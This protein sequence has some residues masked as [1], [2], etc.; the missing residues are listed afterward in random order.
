MKKYLSLLKYEF[1]TIVKDSTNLFMLFYPFVL[2]LLLGVV[3]PLAMDKIEDQNS[4][5]IT[6]LIV[7][8][9]ALSVGAFMIGA[10]LGFSLIENK[11]EKT[12]LNISVTPI[13][14]SGYALFKIIYTY[15]FAIIGNIV[16]IGGLKLIASNDYV[17][18]INNTEIFLLD[19]L[20]WI[21]VVI[22]SFVGSLLVPMVALV[23]ASFAK[24]K[25][26]G[27]VFV[28]SGV[29]LML[30]PTLSLLGLF[31]GAKQ[32]ILGIAPNFWTVKAMLNVATM[33]V[34]KSDLNF[35]LYMLIGAIYS[36][37][38][39]VFSLKLFLKRLNTN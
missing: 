3:I 23:L 12:I 14:V 33:S 6:L 18:N 38:I 36:I 15:L 8:S 29:I 10:L 21:K 2:V 4:T 19:N 9:A 16:I 7:L 5:T 20:P 11:D 25:I 27:L 32:Y 22:F 39:S 31:S 28:K 17:V 1:K 30:I 24:N 26:E 13:K 35:Y 34:D 37:V